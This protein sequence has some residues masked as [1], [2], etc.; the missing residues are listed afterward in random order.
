M[1]R[2]KLAYHRVSDRRFLIVRVQ[3]Y[4]VQFVSTGQDDWR[5]KQVEE[6]LIVEADS[7]QHACNHGQT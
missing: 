7:V 3:T 4:L 6:E 2:K 5:K 1:L